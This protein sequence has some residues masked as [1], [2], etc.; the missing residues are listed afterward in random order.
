MSAG[1]GCINGGQ[2]FVMVATDILRA[3]SCARLG[4]MEQAVFWHVVE[5]TW[6]EATLTGGRRAMPRRYK[7]PVR[8]LAKTL[9]VDPSLVARAKSKL[10]S[11][12]L[13]SESE[14]GLLPNKDVGTW[15]CLSRSAVSYAAEAH[16]SRPLT[17]RSTPDATVDSTVNTDASMLTPEST[18]VDSTVNTLLTLR[19][20]PVDSQVNSEESPPHPLLENAR[21]KTEE[22]REEYTPPPPR[23]HA[24]EASPDALSADD[25]HVAS[26]I[27]LLKANLNTFD[28]GVWLGMHLDALELACWSDETWRVEAAA[29][30][31]LSGR[32]ETRRQHDERTFLNC[33]RY[34]KRWELDIGKPVAAVPAGSSSVPMSKHDRRRIEEEAGWE[35]F[36]RQIKGGVA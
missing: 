36:D 7:L 4:D 1:W 20:T 17:P 26:A 2:P 35:E 9:E 12:G 6:G 5:H 11:K 14:T 25:P 8:G 13:L 24:R 16:K 27:D 30:V 34:A 31:M 15:S 28:L 29:R 10:V 19:S 22:E 32:I 18:P 21:K 33:V 3:V 23:T